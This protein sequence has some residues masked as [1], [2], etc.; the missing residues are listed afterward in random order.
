MIFYTL[1]NFRILTNI[2][3][4]SM[5]NSNIGSLN[6][7]QRE[8]FDIIVKWAIDRIKHLP[9]AIKKQGTSTA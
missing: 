1:N 6:Q 4:D 5:I 9:S 3:Q 2:C 8:V 7:K